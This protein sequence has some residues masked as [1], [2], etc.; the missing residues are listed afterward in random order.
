MEPFR[1]RPLSEADIDAVIEAAGG[2]RAH[3]DASRRD[4]PGAD[5]L[6]GE[7]V[8][9]LKALDD[10]GLAKPERQAKLATLFRRYEKSRPVIVLDRANL[11]DD[12]QR[13]YDRIMEGPI[14]KAVSTA[15]TQLKQS[16]TEFPTASA[17]I[18]F[19][20]NNG[21][22]ALDQEALLQMAAR[23]THNDTSKIDGVVVAG[24][25]YYSDGIDNYFLWPIDYVPINL[26]RPFA[27]YE[28]LREAWGEHATKF[29]SAVML[30]Q[31]APDTIKGPV[32]DTQFDLDGVTYVKPAPPMGKKSVFF[33]EA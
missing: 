12:A 5:Y 18:L 11:P 27:L 7:A 2:V 15:K 20:I 9:E 31:I 24:C 14:K 1:V 32:V 25:Y 6:L 23:R 4:L 33:G 19:L 21:Y 17:S 28:K 10:E 3:A 26:D 30:G 16:R 8:I 29:M 22:T 13:D